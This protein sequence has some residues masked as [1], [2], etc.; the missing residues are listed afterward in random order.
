[1]MP[2]W[3]ERLSTQYS[4]KCIYRSVLKYGYKAEV[5]SNGPVGI[6]VRLSKDGYNSRDVHVTLEPK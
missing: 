6:I 1:M 2:K 4:I 5:V 3:I